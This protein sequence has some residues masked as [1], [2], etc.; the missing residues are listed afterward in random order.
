[1][2]MPKHLYRTH[3]LALISFNLAVDSGAHPPL[4]PNCHY[5]IIYCKF[6]LMT[7]YLP[8]YEGSAWDYKRSGENAIVKALHPVD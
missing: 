4:H 1:M 5:Q 3:Y 6:S 2:H 8:P 7:E